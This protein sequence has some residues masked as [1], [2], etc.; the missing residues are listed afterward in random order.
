MVQNL[1]N[2]LII[3]PELADMRRRLKNL[4]TKDGQVLFVSLY[5]S[6]CHNAVAT[7]SLCL[8]AQAYEHAS[9][10]LQTLYL[11]SETGL[12]VVA[13]LRSPFPF[14]FRWT[15]SFKSWNLLCSHVPSPYPIPLNSD[16][17]LQLLEPEKHPYLFKC[18]YGLLMLLPQSS[19]FATLRNR[20]NS[21]SPIGY[22]HLFPR[23][24]PHPSLNRANFLVS[25][26]QLP[27]PT[28]APRNPK[29]T[30]SNG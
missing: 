26:N 3:A 8:L 11:T 12:I 16:L 10:L 7:F 30:K 4:D 14:L 2:N 23:P 21:I 25:P 13:T 29:R 17:R 15:N 19:A 6:W 20:L 9:N 24:Y 1:H 22:L 28:D 5:N 18:L 27:V